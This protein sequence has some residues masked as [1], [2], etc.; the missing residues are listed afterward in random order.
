MKH[1][2]TKDVQRK[3]GQWKLA[4]AVL[5][6]DESHHIVTRRSQ[7]VQTRTRVKTKRRRRFRKDEDEE[8]H[9]GS[10]WVTGLRFCVH[11]DAK[12]RIPREQ[13][14]PSSLFVRAVHE[15]MRN[16]RRSDLEIISKL[17]LARLASLMKVARR[18]HDDGYRAGSDGKVEE[19]ESKRDKRKRKINRKR[20][21]LSQG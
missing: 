9:S 12:V 13:E 17:V 14:Q 2:K 18:L 20:N 8:N 16:R 4:L 6:C 21:R 11:P 5:R 7:H 19:M 1:V 15:K 10:W 3:N